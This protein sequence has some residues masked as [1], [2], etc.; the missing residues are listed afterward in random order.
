MKRIYNDLEVKLTEIPNISEDFSIKFFTTAKNV[1]IQKTDED[2]TS[3][4]TI[5]LTWPQLR[6]VG[7]GVLEYILTDN[8]KQKTYTGTTYYYIMSDIS[9]DGDEEVSSLTQVVEQIQN[10]ITDIN[11]QLTTKADDND[12]VH[13]H[14]NEEIHGRKWFIDK[15]EIDTYNLYS[16]NEETSVQEMLDNKMD[17]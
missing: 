2:V 3:D 8:V 14:G 16:T 6:S 17:K 12:V 13:L 1:A 15:I 4:N 5:I 9:I 11:T 7:R 10:D